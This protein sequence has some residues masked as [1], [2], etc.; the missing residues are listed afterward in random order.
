MAKNRE[1]ALL[2]EAEVI[3]CQIDDLCTGRPTAAVMYAMALLFGR[4]EAHA[5]RPD[6]DNLMR[7]IRGAAEDAMLEHRAELIEAGIVPRPQ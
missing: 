4:L 2:E 5:E 6:L 1:D 3:A 7:L